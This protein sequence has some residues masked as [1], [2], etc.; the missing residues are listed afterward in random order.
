MLQLCRIYDCT[1]CDYHTCTSDFV[2]FNKKLC[3][4]IDEE[5]GAIALLSKKDG[6]SS[7]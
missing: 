3:A 1:L 5:A 6:Q 4:S 2:S 7:K